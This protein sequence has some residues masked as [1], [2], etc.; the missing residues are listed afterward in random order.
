MVDG[1]LSLEGGIA[2]LQGEL[3][4]FLHMEPKEWT[5]IVEC[6]DKKTEN[7]AVAKRV[8]A[9]YKQLKKVDLTTK[10]GKSKNTDDSQ[11]MKRNYQLDSEEREEVF[12]LQD[13]CVFD[14]GMEKDIKIATVVPSIED[15]GRVSKNIFSSAN[16]ILQLTYHSRL[17]ENYRKVSIAPR[18]THTLNHM[19]TVGQSNG[20]LQ[21]ES[22]ALTQSKIGSISLFKEGEGKQLTRKALRMFTFDITEEQIAE[23]FY[24]EKEEEP[25][26]EPEEEVEDIPEEA[27]PPALTPS[28]EKEK[29]L[30]MESFLRLTTPKRPVKKC[31]FIHC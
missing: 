9:G 17:P 24:E 11:Y 28:R 27:P 7:D 6:V 4:A 29:D 25:E 18:S 22:A 3:L 21:T 19:L 23:Y 8:A 26:V 30:R 12:N 5:V 20:R 2:S 13:K 14:F 16:N 1:L 15:L 31:M 10:S